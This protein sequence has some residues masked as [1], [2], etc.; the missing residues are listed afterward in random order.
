MTTSNEN[1]N[2]IL[3]DYSLSIAD[4]LKQHSDSIFQDVK[5]YDID[6][7][8]MP[9]FE[10]FGFKKSPHLNEVIYNLDSY[11]NSDPAIYWIEILSEHS[12]KDI[13]IPYGG[14]KK[15]LVRKT[16]AY[17]KGFNNW[18]TKILY[19]GKAQSNI[20][21]RMILHLGY[22]GRD[23]LQ[24]LQLCHWKHIQNLRIRLNV[25]YLPSSLAML[26]QVFENQL[27]KILKPI[28]GRHV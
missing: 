4:A 16:P 26:A 21:G 5:T 19:V 3:S 14:F 24:G 12:A 23:N 9:A 27:A 13:H 11:R 25:I 7:S 2:E 15:S 28:L 22:E 1:I 6:C 10:H 8:S 18:G 17:N 20:A